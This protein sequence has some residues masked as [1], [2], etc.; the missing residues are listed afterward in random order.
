MTKKL[1]LAIIV[2]SISAIS[3]NTQAQVSNYLKKKAQQATSRAGQKADEEVTGEMN[4]KVDKGVEKI[5]NKLLGEDEETQT[6]SQGQTQ[7]ENN[8]NSDTETKT[9]QSSDYSSSSSR[10][11]N[12]ESA[13]ANAMLKSFGISTEP[14]NVQENYAYSG[15][16]KMA[17]QSW[18]DNG[19]SEG[20]V[21]YTTYMTSDNSGFA[22]EFL[23][24]KKGKSIMIFDLADEKMIILSDDGNEKAGMVTP[25]A[26]LKDNI[27]EA[28]NEEDEAEFENFSAINPNLKRTGN[29]KMIAGFSCDE[30]TYEDDESNVNLWMTNKLPA[31]LWA[32]MFSA[33][34]ISAAS[35]GNYGGFVMEMDQRDKNSKDRVFMHV[36][37]VNKNQNKNISTSG[38]KLM[39]IGGNQMMNAE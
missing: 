15:N 25:Y 29:S 21:L 33:N 8:Y 20:E 7:T 36:N 30:Y 26:G 23:D 2:L 6:Q 22:M 31:D 34:A 13:A 1:L 10:S 3:I 18:N 28:L 16:I 32:N 19:K 27:N 17:V 12:S 37:E 35:Y 9:N 38:Y 4:E 11:N 24:E 14:V 5:F 39:S